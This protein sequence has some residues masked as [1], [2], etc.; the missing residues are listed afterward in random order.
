MK[1]LRTV[2]AYIA[3]EQI[4]WRTRR[5]SYKDIDI[6]EYWLM[7]NTIVF[8]IAMWKKNSG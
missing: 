5:N 8:I 4:S 7:P 6:H 2:R 3:A 1:P